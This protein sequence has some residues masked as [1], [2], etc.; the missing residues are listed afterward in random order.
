MSSGVVYLEVELLCC[1]VENTTVRVTQEPVRAV[2]DEDVAGNEAVGST[3][4]MPQ[5]LR[6]DVAVAGG[7]M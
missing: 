3:I 7:G 1:G 2:I 4:K 6:G 5:S